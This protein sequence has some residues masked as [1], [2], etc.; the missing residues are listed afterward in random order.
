MKKTIIAFSLFSLMFLPLAVFAENPKHDHSGHD[1]SI[2]RKAPHTENK[3]MDHTNHMGEMIR[4]TNSS[5]PP[6]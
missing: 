2:H 1:H 3:G 4:E 5:V 6:Q